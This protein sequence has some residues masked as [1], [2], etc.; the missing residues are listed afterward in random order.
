MLITARAQNALFLLVFY[1]MCVYGDRLVDC[2]NLHR[3]I[4]AEIRAEI[5]DVVVELTGLFF[6]D[7][8]LSGFGGGKIFFASSTR[9]AAVGLCSSSRS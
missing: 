1:S 8:Q 3:I 4:V 6:E 7:R 2:G 9:K 5:R